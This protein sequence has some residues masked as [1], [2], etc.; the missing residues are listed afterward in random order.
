MSE[1][2]TNILGYLTLAAILAAIWILFGE[3]PTRDQ[4]A[5][6]ERS[7]A[8]L[9]ERINETALVSI[10]NDEG[11]VTLHRDT[12]GWYVNERNGFPANIDKVRAFLRG[13]ALSERREPKTSNIDRFDR[14]GLASTAT[15][16]ALKDD[17]GGTLLSVKLGTRK[18]SNNGRSLT[19]M[20]QDTD[21]RAW[22][23][24]GIE[25]ADIDPVEWLD[26]DV[27]HI[28]NARIAAVTVNDAALSRTS[29]D[30][31]FILEN[32][33]EGTALQPA[34]LRAEPAQL[35][36]LLTVED[37]QKVNNPLADAIAE[38]SLK[39][40]DGLALTVT[41][42]NYQEGNWI[43]V[44]ATSVDNAGGDVPAEAVTINEKV[45]GWLFKIADADAEILKRRKS[46][47]VQIEQTEGSPS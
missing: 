40:Y 41:V 6:G 4:G 33:T 7:F 45:S 43:K 31:G 42:F 25:A 18:G 44:T 28:E 47:F 38:V 15:E 27:L 46:D 22:L 34:W 37:V 21:T 10:T 20:F 39:T 35:F 32:V 26:K 3:D 12:N 19:Y 16:V 30:A 1:R 11:A 23:V 14:L 36:T 17:T 8:G 29:S 5:R 9:S 2:M 13:F 24:T